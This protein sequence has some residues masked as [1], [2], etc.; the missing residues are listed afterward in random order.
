MLG[1][2]WRRIVRIGSVVT[3]NRRGVGIWAFLNGGG[4]GGGGG[5]SGTT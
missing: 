3:S 4:G 5:D 2:L 1:A